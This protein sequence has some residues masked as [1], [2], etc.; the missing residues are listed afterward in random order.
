[1]KSK[2]ASL[3]NPARQVAPVADIS[4]RSSI[5]KA[6]DGPKKRDARVKFDDGVVEPDQ[7]FAENEGV[8]GKEK[9][10]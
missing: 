8:E 7:F 3:R 6:A 4:P 1:M 9:A 10:E 2:F 5:L